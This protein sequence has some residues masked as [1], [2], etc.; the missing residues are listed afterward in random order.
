MRQ[1][2]P[3]CHVHTDAGC[4]LGLMPAMTYDNVVVMLA[5]SE[6]M[7]DVLRLLRPLVLNSARVVGERVRTEGWTVGMRAVVEA[8]TEA[9]EATVPAIGR[10]MDLPRQAVQRHVDDLLARGHVTTHP[11]PSHRRSML[12]ALTPAGQ[13]AIERVRTSEFAELAALAPECTEADLLT[14][15][16]VLR[17]LDRDIRVKAVARREPVI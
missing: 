15:L 14:A 6:L 11:N 4:H 2:A 9:G 12:V 13:A 1:L 7:C 17:C 10:V 8:L 5:R 16:R 3:E